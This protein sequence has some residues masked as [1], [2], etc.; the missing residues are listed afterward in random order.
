M[1][2]SRK[3]PMCQKC[4]QPMAG[5]RRPNGI[6]ICPS[7]K[8]PSPPPV[9]S[10]SRL[11]LPPLPPASPSPLRREDPI[12][13]DSL[14]DGTQHRRNPHWVDPSPPPNSDLERADT[15]GSM[16]PTEPADDN[17]LSPTT[18]RIKRERDPTLPILIEEDT[19]ENVV[20][21]LSSSV[22]SVAS[23]TSRLSR[24]LTE[25]LM[26]C[27]PLVSIFGAPREDLT[28]VTRE[29]RRKGLYTAIVHSNQEETPTRGGSRSTPAPNNSWMVLMG[30]DVNA[31]ASWCEIHDR[32]RIRL[33][34]QKQITGGRMDLLF[35]WPGWIMKALSLVMVAIVSSS[36]VVYF[37][38]IS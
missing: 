21:A 32:E 26:N 30:H 7:P 17:P 1:S 13:F 23:S 10:S 34:E 33:L 16:V 36:M 31:V 14:P 2:P 15:P 22:T 20:D 38:S 6:P 5:H 11:S 24:S 9:A 28:T 4:G 12:L 3:K 18:P 29:A 25:V 8:S 37:L 27:T 19:D 35:E